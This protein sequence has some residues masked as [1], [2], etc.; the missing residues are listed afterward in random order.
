MRTYALV[1]SIFLLSFCML[2]QAQQAVA[3]GVAREFLLF[4]VLPQKTLAVIGC[5]DFKKAKEGFCGS[6]CG[7]FWQDAEIQNFIKTLAK[8]YQKEID[9][10]LARFERE[11]GLKLQDVLAIPAGEIILAVVDVNPENPQMPVSAAL[12]FKMNDANIARQLI[13]RSPIN[14]EKGIFKEVEIYTSKE[15]PVCYA[16]LGNTLLV[17]TADGLL[18]ETISA[19]KDGAKG[20]LLEKE[21]FNKLEKQL[22]PGEAPI[23]F[24]LYLNTEEAFKKFD[25]MIPPVAPF[26]QLGVK[27]ITSLSGAAIVKDGEIQTNFYM[28]TSQKRG[29]H[30]LYNAGNLDVA[31]HAANAP[32]KSIDFAVGGFNLLRFLQNVEEILSIIDPNGGLTAQYKEGIQFVESN[33]NLK[34]KEELAVAFESENSYMTF[35]PEGGGLLPQWLTIYKVADKAKAEKVVSTFAKLLE[36]E[37]KSMSHGSHT[38]QYF[39]SKLGS[40]DAFMRQLRPRGFEPEVV[41]D[42]IASAFSGMAFLYDGDTFYFAESAHCIMEYLDWKESK[43]ASLAN[44]EH[45]Q[46]QLKMASPN[47]FVFHY[48]NYKPIVKVLWNTLDG[49]LRLFEGSM[50]T[51]G[52]PY[53]SALFPRSQTITKYM[54]VGFIAMSAEEDGLKMTLSGTGNQIMIVG[55]LLIGGGAAVMIPAFS[56]VTEKAKMTK[57]KANLN[58]LG[59]GCMIYKQDYGRNVRMPSSLKELYDKQIFAETKLFQCPMKGESREFR[60][61]YGY[62]YHPKTFRPFRDTTTTILAYCKNHEKQVVVLFVDG[63]VESMYYGEFLQQFNRQAEALRRAG[64]RVDRQYGVIPSEK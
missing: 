58:M 64:V 54:G 13:E 5:P 3:G 34:I 43:G 59:K 23:L 36:L 51:A 11:S 35:F 31:K 30:K 19:Y 7:K 46:K 29:I 49:V 22:C 39:A 42:A 16:I 56:S 25:A 32:A 33:I 2:P 6:Q 57:C 44:D 26:E 48:M 62:L 21:S 4:D 18:Q 60:C 10:A 55:G 15:I 1:F 9:H 38:I 40:P 52:V 47:A 17:C 37:V 61:D 63:H 53:E 20:L 12:S 50:R 24:G 28:Q 8:P 27:D 14:F 41:K 45:F